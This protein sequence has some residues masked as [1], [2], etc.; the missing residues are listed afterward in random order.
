MLSRNASTYDIK[1]VIE[2]SVGFFYSSSYGHIHPALKKLEKNKLVSITENV[3]NGRNR[4]EYAITP[5][6]RNHFKA[7]LQLEIN[8]GKTQDEG[9]LR[10]FFLAELPKA[11]QI[12]LLNNYLNKLK[13]KI[14]DLKEVEKEIRKK[15]IPKKLIKAFNYKVETLD[16][17]I[18]YYNFVIKWY[19]NIMRKIKKG[20]YESK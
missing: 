16:F 9:L 12:I 6:G 18:Q 2:G 20:Q 3:V 14:V 15:D 5:K 13:Q 1:K 8:V 7:W 19:E 4:K 10:M 11:K 17:G